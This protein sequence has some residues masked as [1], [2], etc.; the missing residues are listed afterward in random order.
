ML[1]LA[2]IV[3]AA[4]AQSAMPVYALR[5]YAVRSSVVPS[6]GMKCAATPAP[7]STKP[8]AVVW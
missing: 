8:V 4:L 7:Q 6:R 5:S 3:V 1:T 2:V